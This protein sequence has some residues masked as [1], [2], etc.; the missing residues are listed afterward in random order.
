MNRSKA[1]D[2]LRA[3]AIFLVL[4]RHMASCPVSVSPL[5][6]HLTTT[7][8]RGGWVGV[9]LFFVL[10]GFLVSGLL[11]REQEKFGTISA[12]N[13]LV[14]RGLK[15]YPP[16][17][18][19]VAA[20]LAHAAWAG[21]VAQLRSLDRREVA[22]ELLFF[23]NYHAGLWTHTWSLA[24]EEHF[25]LFLLLLLMGLSALSAHR[26][27]PGMFKLVPAAFATLAALCLSLRLLTAHLSPLQ[28]DPHLYPTHLRMDSLFAGVL[29]SYLYHFHHDAL[30]AWATRH[31]K[32]LA[33]SGVI[34]F[35]PAFIFPLEVTPFIYTFGLTLFYLG[36][37]CLLAAALATPI[38][39][40]SRLLSALAYIGSH[41]YSIY[42]WH[43]PFA[44]WVI[45]ALSGREVASQR[46]FLF[47]AEY[48]LG[49]ILIGIVLSILTEYPVLRL[50][51]RLFPSRARPLTVGA[52]T[53]AQGAK[54]Q[55]DLTR[56]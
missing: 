31:R 6:F 1:I 8:T 25:Y 40:R 38:S 19:L 16:F 29:I 47:F 48:L 28:H 32:I 45:P 43:V 54:E 55:G 3:M 34:L 46:W 2:I 41:S 35:A 37:S 13:F 39:P 15:I 18:L 5:L 44:I 20:T 11:F 36:G 33:A 7:W 56:K 22:A 14:R 49:T 26:A 51:D 9:D 12:K 52:Q 23:Q 27:P 17:W 4:G 30:L 53:P 24:V 10:S 21:G 42:L 50:R